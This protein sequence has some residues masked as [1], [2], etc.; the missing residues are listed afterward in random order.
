VSLPAGAVPLAED[1][2][3]PSL[4]YRLDVEQGRIRGMTDGVEAVKQAVYKILE[5]ERYAHPIYSGYGMDR[6]IGPEQERC[7]KEALLEDDRIINIVDYKTVVN[8]DEASI[9]FTVVT[10]YGDITIERR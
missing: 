4:T 7:V 10:L 8:G 6:R 2:V 5:T 3:H 9:Q 1:A